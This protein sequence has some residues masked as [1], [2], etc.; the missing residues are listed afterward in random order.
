MKFADFLLLVFFRLFFK[1]LVDLAV[2][3]LTVTHTPRGGLGH[4]RDL[5]P[6]PGGPPPLGLAQQ[7]AS[8]WTTRKSSYF[9]FLFYRKEKRWSKKPREKKEKTKF[10]NTWKKER[11]RQPRWKGANR[12]RT[13]SCTVIFHRLRFVPVHW[14]ASGGL[15]IDFNQMVF[16]AVSWRT[17]FHVIM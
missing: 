5:R 16:T 14:A 13:V 12:T 4:M 8:H 10:L 7:M 9:L 11:R 2:L 6:Q 1:P 3:G 17:S 15:V